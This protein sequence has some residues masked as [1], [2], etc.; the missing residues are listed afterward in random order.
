MTTNLKKKCR[1]G[2]TMVV[3]NGQ[4][5][6]NVDTFISIFSAVTLGFAVAI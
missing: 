4:L 2:K 5:G 3:K 6:G 1:I